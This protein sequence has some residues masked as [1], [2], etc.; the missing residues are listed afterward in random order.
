MP[1]AAPRPSRREV[2][3]LASLASIDPR[4]AER[5]L[6]EGLDAVRGMV[7]ERVAEALAARGAAHMPVQP[8]AGVVF[9]EGPHHR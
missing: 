4:T 7:R 3:A 2:L 8:M 5:V 1:H 6:I 9:G